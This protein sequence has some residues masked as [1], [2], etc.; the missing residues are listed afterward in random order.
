MALD[1]NLLPDEF[2]G[3]GPLDEGYQSVAPPNIRQG[4]QH[5]PQQVIE[6][7][8]DAPDNQ[9]DWGPPPQTSN[10]NQTLYIIAGVMTA[11]ILLVLVGIFVV[12]RFFGSTND[13]QENEQLTVEQQL[14]QQ[15]ENGTTDTST[16]DT[17]ENVPVGSCPAF[18]IPDEILAYEG[19]DL[20]EDI[21]VA[22]TEDIL[23]AAVDGVRYY[24]LTPR[25]TYVAVMPAIT[26][27][28]PMYNGQT[29]QPT[30]H[31]MAAWNLPMGQNATVTLLD[32]NNQPA[33]RTDPLTGI[34]YT[35]EQKVT[36]S[37]L[38]PNFSFAPAKVTARLGHQAI[39]DLDPTCKNTDGSFNGVCY[40]RTYHVLITPICTQQ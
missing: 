20:G 8:A 21:G 36:N 35:V 39:I 4:T 22:L 14:A 16:E 34:E 7:P 17:T 1:D 33:K 38:G 19:V 30:L 2:E 28:N 18:P 31:V 10:S 23:P 5:D 15:L 12:P 3:F 29:Y 32:E 13:L 26:I 6:I 24:D 40:D 37:D 9:D 25:N 11:V 27:G